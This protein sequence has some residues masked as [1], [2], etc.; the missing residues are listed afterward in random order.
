MPNPL[1]SQIEIDNNV[2]DIKD[3]EARNKISELKLSDLKT[4]DN[5]QFVSKE[6]KEKWDSGSITIDDTLSDTSENPVQ[7]KVIKGELDKVFQSVSDGKSKIASAI[8]DKGVKTDKDATFDIMADNIKKIETDDTG[9][10]PVLT[11]EAFYVQPFF[12]YSSFEVLTGTLLGIKEEQL[13]IY[14]K[15]N[16]IEEP[17]EKVIEN[18]PYV[19]Q[20]YSAPANRQ[21]AYVSKKNNTIS[22]WNL[23]GML[24]KPATPNGGYPYSKYPYTILVSKNR[25]PIGIGRTPQTTYLEYSTLEYQNEIYYYIV[26]NINAHW[27]DPGITIP[28]KDNIIPFY[29]YDINFTNTKEGKEYIVKTLINLYNKAE[30]KTIYEIPLN[31]TLINNSNYYGVSLYKWWHDGDRH[32]LW[33]NIPYENPTLAKH[34]WWAIG[35]I[36]K[37]NS[38]NLAQITVVMKERDLLEL[39]YINNN[40]NDK[41]TTI[42]TINTIDYY[43]TTYYYIS[44]TG[45]AF[46][47]IILNSVMKYDNITFQNINE[48]ETQQNAAKALLDLYFNKGV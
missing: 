12:N 9:V 36:F 15:D 23:I 37:R 41:I 32:Y 45:V 3:A 20:L 30:D 14:A 25:Y 40:N 10:T 35:G 42:N 19:S 47:N 13:A 21:Q 17:F 31:F 38:D 39:Y 34:D 18:G 16:I 24:A 28:V 43:D 44:T 1:V 4:D 5:H 7:N 48:N 2:Y 11:G 6:E 8:T 22:N 33:W 46:N 29:D 26:K 27:N